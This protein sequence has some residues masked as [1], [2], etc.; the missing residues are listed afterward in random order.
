MAERDSELA[1]R[2]LNEITALDIKLSTRTTAY[3]DA[4]IA[5][6]EREIA[7]T[8]TEKQGCL[9]ELKQL[10]AVG[11]IMK[12]LTDSG[13]ASQ[14]RLSVALAQ[15]EAASTRCKMADVRLS[16]S[17]VELAAAPAMGSFSAMV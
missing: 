7:G 5:R 1:V 8:K 17:D 9:A 13:Y 3:H 10:G 2:Q 11:S 16:R 12:T 15:Q 4:A 6:L 14:L